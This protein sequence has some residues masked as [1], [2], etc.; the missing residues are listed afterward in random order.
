MRGCSGGVP[1]VWMNAGNSD[2]IQVPWTPAHCN[3]KLLN[4]SHFQPVE[5]TEELVLVFQY[6]KEGGGLPQNVRKFLPGGGSGHPYFWLRDV[7]GDPADGPHIGE[8]PPQGGEKAVGD[9]TLETGGCDMEISTYGNFLT[10]GRSGYNRS[11]H[12]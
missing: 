1:R 4:I 10:G 11:V 12:I 6:P 5:G 9:S 7:G 3:G 8:F 2:F